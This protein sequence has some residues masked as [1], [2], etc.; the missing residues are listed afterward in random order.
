MYGGQN[1]FD[2]TPR[3]QYNDMW[4]LA[5]PSFTWIQIT[6]MSGSPAGRS[7]HTCHAVGGQMVVVGGYLG[8]LSTQCDSPGIYVFDMSSLEWKSSF[9]SLSVYS[10]PSLVF[11]ATGESQW[12]DPPSPTQSQMVTSPTLTDPLTSANPSMRTMWTTA[13][14]TTTYADGQTSIITTSFQTTAT[15]TATPASSSPS[16]LSQNSITGT[17]LAAIVG[18]SLSAVILLLVCGWCFYALT[19]RKRDVSWKRLSGGSLQR[20]IASPEGPWSP[21]TER[22]WPASDEAESQTR[23]WDVSN[24]DGNVM[25]SPRQSLRVVNE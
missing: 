1:V 17:K 22:G 23:E 25:F 13:T 15:V 12:P 7:G 24:W 9:D 3:P 10:I 11:S 6:G 8:P 21:T 20:P 18:G 4:I 14:V 2:A 16:S 19:K 5:L